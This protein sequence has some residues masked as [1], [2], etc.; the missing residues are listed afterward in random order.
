MPPTACLPSHHA[1]SMISLN[2]DWLLHC[3]ECSLTLRASHLR[4]TLL[5]RG[6]C[7]DICCSSCSCW[8]SGTSSVLRPH[9]PS[10]GTP[11]HPL[12]LRTRRTLHAH[13]ASAPFFG[14]CVTS[15]ALRVLLNDELLRFLPR[16]MRTSRSVSTGFIPSSRV[17]SG[18]TH[19][20]HDAKPECSR[21]FPL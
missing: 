11:D 21:C 5:T 18:A 9:L 3:I 17:A 15:I 16:V 4:A 13:H 14:R 1:S 12:A 10:S 2:H 19:H 8:I 7:I 6:A 20:G